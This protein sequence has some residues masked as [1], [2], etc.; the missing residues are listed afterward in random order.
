M[1]SDD[2]RF[3][4]ITSALAIH[5]PEC[6]AVRTDTGVA[7]TRQRGQRG[8][9]VAMLAGLGWELMAPARQLRPRLGRAPS[10]L[11]PHV[12]PAGTPVATHP[13]LQRRR[14][15]AQRLMGPADARPC[16]AVLLGRHSAG[17]SHRVRQPGT[18][19]LAELVQAAEGGRVR[20][21]EGSF[22]RVEVVGWAV[23]DF[24]PRQTSTSTRIATRRPTNRPAMH[25]LL[26]M[27]LHVALSSCCF[28]RLP[29]TRQ[30]IA[31]L[32]P[33]DP[34]RTV[35]SETINKKQ[36]VSAHHT[37]SLDKSS[38]KQAALLPTSTTI[39]LTS[40]VRLTTPGKNCP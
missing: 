38:R 21:S 36:P 14:P 19:A 29:M 27:E 11:T 32:A 24:H 31:P 7:V 30:W 2:A 12:P 18:P 5:E 33:T 23:S 6:K 39:S 25:P 22:R 3:R 4:G 28:P 26:E 9:L 34:M 13:D 8:H 40:A 35:T 16:P 37:A 17:T 1:V 20:T 10:V 15:P